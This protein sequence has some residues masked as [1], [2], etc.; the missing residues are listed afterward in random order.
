MISTIKTLKAFQQN[1][2]NFFSKKYTLS[3][4]Q[5]VT[6]DCMAVIIFI[7]VHITNAILTSLLYVFI[8]CFTLISWK[9]KP[10]INS[11]LFC[12]FIYNYKTNK[13]ILIRENLEN[14]EKCKTF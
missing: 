4:K 9:G 8:S 5:P 14:I 12:N 6:I 3:D 11:F 10:K 2:S 7:I 1:I 13:Q